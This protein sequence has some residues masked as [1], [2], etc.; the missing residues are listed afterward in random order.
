[1]SGLSRGVRGKKIPHSRNLRFQ[2]TDWSLT[3]NVGAC[4][5]HIDD[6]N[7]DDYNEHDHDHGDSKNNDSGNNFMMVMIMM[8]IT[9]TKMNIW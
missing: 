5:T 4:L 7:D 8:T 9:V 3:C 2:L 1:M 6:G